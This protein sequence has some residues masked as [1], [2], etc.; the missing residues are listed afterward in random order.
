MPLYRRNAY[1]IGVGGEMLQWRWILWQVAI[2]ILG[3]IGM[4]A[5]FLLAWKTGEPPDWA[6]KWHPIIEDVTP[7]ALIFY[8]MTLIG[9]TI[10]DFLPKFSAHIPF[11]VSLAVVAIAVTV[12]ASFIVIWH[13]DANWHVR[14]PV[15][16]VTG[17][18]LVLSIVMCH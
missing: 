18:L 5:I 9:A 4:S 17:F 15:Y 14:S 8:S 16:Y 3:P 13:Q 6:I 7:W 12:Y 10:D 11:G 2:P 1:T